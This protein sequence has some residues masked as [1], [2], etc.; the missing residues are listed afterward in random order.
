MPLRLSM[1][2]LGELIVDKV[3]PEDV[4]RQVSCACIVKVAEDASHAGG[5]RRVLGRLCV[6]G[7][8]SSL[9]DS[10]TVFYV[11]LLSSSSSLLALDVVEIK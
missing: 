8:G 4:V 1:C 5:Y 2:C 6:Q 7:L 9:Y 10:L 3:F 11:I